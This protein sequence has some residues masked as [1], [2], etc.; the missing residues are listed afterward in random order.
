M[1][2]LHDLII[3]CHRNAVEKHFY[4]ETQRAEM[5]DDTGQLMYLTWQLHDLEREVQRQRKRKVIWECSFAGP[6]YANYVKGVGDYEGYSHIDG[7]DTRKIHIVRQMLHMAGEIGE[8][9]DAWRKRGYEEIDYEEFADIFIVWA[10]IA[11]FIDTKKVLSAIE[12]KM[13]KNEEREIGYGRAE[14]L[15]FIDLT[16]VPGIVE[17]LTGKA[18]TFDELAK[19]WAEHVYIT[20]EKMPEVNDKEEVKKD[21]EKES[22]KESEENQGRVFRKV[23]GDSLRQSLQGGDTEPLQK[24]DDGIERLSK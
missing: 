3:L 4:D 12:R 21:E 1:A 20:E 2:S 11:G 13:K 22:H 17:E 9:L 6:N 19:T 16:A 14:D 8:F 7:M 24:A 23:Y 18:P 5:P 10:D 15:G